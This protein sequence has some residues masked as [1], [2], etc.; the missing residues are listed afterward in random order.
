VNRIWRAFGLQPHRTATFKLS[1]DPQFVEKVRD[2][3]GLYLDPPDKALVVWVDEKSQIQAL[4]RTQP[5][6]P[7]RPGQPERR[8]H[9]Y[10]RHGTTT[11]F[12]GFIAAVTAKTEVKPGTV[13]G[14]CMPRHRA[15]ELRSFLDEIDANVPR[16]ARHPCRHGQR[17]EPQDQAHSRLVRPAAALARP[18]HAD[19]IILD[20]LGRA[21]LRTHRREADQAWGAPVG[22]GP[23]G[24][25]G[26]RREGDRRIISG[27]VHVLCR[28]HAG[29]T[30]PANTAP[31]RRSTIASTGGPSADAGPP[32]R[33]MPLPM[34]VIRVV[35]ATR[36]PDFWSSK[37]SPYPGR[38]R[39]KN[40]RRYAQ[41]LVSSPMRVNQS[42]YQS[43]VALRRCQLGG[44]P[45]SDCSITSTRE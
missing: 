7:M 8:T 38:Q 32:L 15:R 10:E 44:V 30:V 41:P 26:P 11:L 31:I 33:P 1:T 43:L 18:L 14:K 2:I 22:E 23:S 16:G 37:E 28:E 39:Q 3:V 40:S 17:V 12:A 6:L 9:D 35:S 29:A 13:I 25:C 45:D 20:Q 27:V 19:V 42:S 34:S 24:L 5:M 21:L 4:D 36:S